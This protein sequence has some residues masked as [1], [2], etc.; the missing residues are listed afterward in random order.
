MLCEYKRTKATTWQ[1]TSVYAENGKWNWEKRY[2]TDPLGKERWYWV[3][4]QDKKVVTETI[5]RVTT[6]TEKGRMISDDCPKTLP[7]THKF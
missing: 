1:G 6:Q 2:F 5:F 4:V 3:Y 7:S